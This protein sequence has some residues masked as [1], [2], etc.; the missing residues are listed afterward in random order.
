[1][2]ES[3]ISEG[4]RYGMHHFRNDVIKIQTPDLTFVVILFLFL[5]LGFFYFHNL[6]NFFSKTSS[7]DMVF[8]CLLVG[9]C[10]LSS[11]YKKV[12]QFITLLFIAGFIVFYIWLFYLVQTK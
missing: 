11:L 2:E 7:H 9:T 5:P 3:N 4:V 12:E 6:L 10:I 8:Y 1:M